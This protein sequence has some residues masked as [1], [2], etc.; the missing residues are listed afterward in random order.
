[1]S[2][3]EFI[4]SLTREGVEGELLKTIF[5]SL[6]ASFFLLGITYYLKLRY[7]PEFPQKYG[8]YIFFSILSYALI[9]PSLRQVRAYKEF[10]CM[11]GMMIGMT[12]GMIAG[13][14]S[15]FYVGATNGM[16]GGSIFGIAIGIFF[17]YENGKCCGIMGTMEGM[18]AG[19]MG[20]LMGAMTAMMMLNDNIKIFGIIIFLISGAIMFG[21]NFMIYKETKE[22]ER[23]HKDSEWFIIFWSLFLTILTI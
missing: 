14:L 17:G 4:K 16:F 5:V 11:S 7:I 3:R 15:G 23:K 19:F 1:M 21:L 6:V 22:V 20:G 2:F 10:P 13:F 12:I 8:F 18:I 9:I